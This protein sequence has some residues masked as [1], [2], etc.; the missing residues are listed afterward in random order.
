MSSQTGCSPRA[1][2]VKYRIKGVAIVAWNLEGQGGGSKGDTMKPTVSHGWGEETLE[3][4]AR[5]FQSL[6]L[7]ERMDMLCWFT[8][9]ILSANPRIVEQKN[10]EPVA[11]RVLVLTQTPRQVRHHQ[12]NG[13]HSARGAPRHV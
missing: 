6:T 2:T 13:G 8:D 11:G 10:A 5:W 4:K 9:L 1:E 12:R 7:A 3:A